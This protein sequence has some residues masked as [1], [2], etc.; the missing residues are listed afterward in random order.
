M[1]SLYNFKSSSKRESLFLV[2]FFIAVR[3][4]FSQPFSKYFLE[5]Y[6]Y[7]FYF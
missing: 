7:L 3:T 4:V 6:T 1:F 2:E 5:V